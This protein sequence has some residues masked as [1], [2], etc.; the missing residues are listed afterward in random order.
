MITSGAFNS[1]ETDTSSYG[2]DWT[3]VYEGRFSRERELYDWNYTAEVLEHCRVGWTDSRWVPLD[4]WCPVPKT[5]P[6]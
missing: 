5:R 6:P 4:P 2:N 3:V 1:D